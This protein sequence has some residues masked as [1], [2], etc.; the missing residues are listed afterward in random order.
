[1][2]EM[3]NIFAALAEC[4]MPMEP[5]LCG[6]DR[7]I[8]AGARAVGVGLQLRRDA[9]RARAVVCAQRGTL[10]EMEKAGFDIVTAARFP[11]GRRQIAEDER[12]VITFEGAELVR[13]GGGPRCMTCPV[14]S[15]DPWS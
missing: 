2:R 9:A 12:A 4:G 8:D 15:D 6:G 5:M 14:V 7:R 3:P 11:H 1:M 13:G 10:R